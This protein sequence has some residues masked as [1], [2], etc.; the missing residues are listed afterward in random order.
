MN[1]CH[2]VAI[3][4]LGVFSSFGLGFWMGYIVGCICVDRRDAKQPLDEFRG[5]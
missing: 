2:V 3:L 1:I 5:G 4:L